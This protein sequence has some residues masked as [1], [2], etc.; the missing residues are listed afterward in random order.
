MFGIPRLYLIAGAVAVLVAGVWVYGNA[1]YKSGVRDTT[2][3]SL[4]NDM[5]GASD[6]HSTAKETRRSIGDGGDAGELLRETG[7]LRDD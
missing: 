4:R 6:V 5:E 3:E 2:A 7:G 1:K